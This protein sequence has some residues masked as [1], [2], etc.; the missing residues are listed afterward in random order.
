MLYL[1]GYFVYYSVSECE[2]SG[3]DAYD[4][5]ICEYILRVCGDVV[6]VMSCHA[7]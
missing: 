6:D 7:T 4:A 2:G 1:A 5:H 3:V